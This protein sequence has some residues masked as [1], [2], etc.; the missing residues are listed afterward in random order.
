MVCGE[1]AIATLVPAVPPKD[2]ST[3]NAMIIEYLEAKGWRINYS[4]RCGMGTALIQ[5][6]TACS[7]DSAINNSP[8]EIGDS[9]LCITRHDR[10]LNYRSITFTHDVWLMLM[11]YPL[12]CWE[13][14]VVSHTVSQYG[15][16]LI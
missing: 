5:F 8:Y 11:N 16:F 7:R 10:S 4:S 6:T 15:R 2:F 14:G 9:V 3:A 12:E 1:W 13:V